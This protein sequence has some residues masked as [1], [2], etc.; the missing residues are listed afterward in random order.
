MLGHPPLKL[1][2]VTTV[3]RGLLALLGG[4]RARL[5]RGALGFLVDAARRHGA[6]GERS[7]GRGRA[8]NV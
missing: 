8:A 3:L 4:F 1:G 7:E 2:L 6:R 5:R